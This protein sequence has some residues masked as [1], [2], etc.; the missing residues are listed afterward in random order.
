MSEARAAYQCAAPNPNGIPARW[1]RFMLRMAA[2]ERGKV[3]NITVIMPDKADCEPQWAI[4]SGAK[5]ENAN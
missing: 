5:V 4:S 2:L 1:V 3:Y